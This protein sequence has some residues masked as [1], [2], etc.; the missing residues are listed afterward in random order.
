MTGPEMLAGNIAAAVVARL[1]PL[2]EEAR[3]TPRLLTLAQA[4]VYL[5]RSPDAVRKLVD[6]GAFPS[7]RTDARLMVDIRDLDGWIERNKVGG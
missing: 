3:V 7:V 6:R 4:G 5:G 1:K 2:L